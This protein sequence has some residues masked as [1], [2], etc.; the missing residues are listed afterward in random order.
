MGFG[1]GA[2][3]SPS[4]A[5]TCSSLL[6]IFAGAPRA[7]VPSLVAAAALGFVFA[8]VVRWLLQC[9]LPL[10]FFGVPWACFAGRL[11]LRGDVAIAV[12]A[13]VAP[14]GCVFRFPGW[15]RACLRLS[16]FALP[17]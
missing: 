9:R 7:D 11:A 6:V 2:S 17:L 8:S 5:A 16:V 3:F 15:S 12:V 14:V 4:V 1:V 10:L 13:G